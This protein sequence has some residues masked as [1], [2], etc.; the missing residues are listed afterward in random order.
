[1]NQNFSYIRQKGESIKVGIYHSFET[2]F[3]LSFQE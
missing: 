3:G 1:M 2:N